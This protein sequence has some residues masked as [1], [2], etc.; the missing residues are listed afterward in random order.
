[1]AANVETMFYTGE[2]P[3]HGMGVSVVEAPNS[4]DAI[5]LAGLDW[6]VDKKPAGF[7][8]NPESNNRL[9]QG[10]TAVKDDYYNV[11][12]TDNRPLGR[13]TERYK[14]VQNEEAFDF[15]DKLL[16]AGVTYET[17]GSLANGK[18]IWMTAR[19]PNTTVLGDDVAPYLVFTNSHD[20]SGAVK[21]AIT[22]VRVV[23]QN[24]LTIALRRAKRVASIKHCG[25]I[26]TKVHEAEKVLGLATTY[27]GKMREE[28]EV[29]QEIKIDK[30][31]FK[32]FLETMFPLPAGKTEDDLTERAKANIDSQREAFKFLYEEKEDIQKFGNSGWALLNA[33]G[34]F[35]PHFKPARDTSTY[36]ENNFMKI[37][38]GG[39]NNLMERASQFVYKM[40]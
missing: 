34:D 40:A 6:R 27:M 16:G 12:A 24:T 28:A 36:R 14:V 25:D 18:R 10:F 33:V 23:C 21:V 13:V 15:T 11:R 20:G 1:M 22:P 37:V 19:M 4:A 39:K 35:V 32:L 31:M 8:V 5:R 7:L 9:T 2:V 29:L 30:D 26:R 17:A 38:D 3:W